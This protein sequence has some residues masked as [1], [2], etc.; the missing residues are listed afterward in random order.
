LRTYGIEDNHHP[1]EE[2]F[3]LFGADRSRLFSAAEA[4]PIKLDLE[5]K[6]TMLLTQ[7]EIIETEKEE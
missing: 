3:S 7:G 6:D 5:I 2:L 1:V 4:I